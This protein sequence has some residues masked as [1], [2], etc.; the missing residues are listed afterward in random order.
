MSL[1]NKKLCGENHPKMMIN[2]NK[3]G[4]SMKKAG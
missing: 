1:K 3:A 2:W 4:M